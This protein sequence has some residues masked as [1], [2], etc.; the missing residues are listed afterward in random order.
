MA[1]SEANIVVW[2]WSEQGKPGFKGYLTILS[3]L[4]QLSA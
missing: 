2:D 1:A 3:F 4:Q